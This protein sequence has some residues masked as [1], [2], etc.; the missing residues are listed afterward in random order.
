MDRAVEYAYETRQQFPDRRVFLSGEII[1]NP[2]VN[3]R[4]QAMDILILPEN[5][6]AL[7]RYA[8]VTRATS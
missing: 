5:K 3:G 4:M 7:A 2:D 8:E 6:D 1:H